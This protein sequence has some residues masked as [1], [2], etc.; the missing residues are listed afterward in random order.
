MHANKMELASSQA[1]GLSA[2][3]GS[4]KN[5]GMAAG[6]AHTG[7][8]PL[9]SHRYQQAAAAKTARIFLPAAGNRND[10]SLNNQGT[11]G[12]Y[13]SST[14]NPSN[15]NNARNLNFNSGGANT[16]NNN[17]CNGQSVRAV[18]STCHTLL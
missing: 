17:R 7:A 16:N 15:S 11:N 2:P 8:I 3:V 10:A 9:T 6:F 14:V 12:N 13:W 18:L 5:S 1:A 4:E